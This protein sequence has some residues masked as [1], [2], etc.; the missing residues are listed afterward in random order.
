M[1]KKF[2]EFIYYFW[3]RFSI[4]NF[5][6]IMRNMYMCV[7]WDDLQSKKPILSS[8]WILWGFEAKRILYHGAHQNFI[9][10]TYCLTNFKYISRLITAKLPWLL[11]WC[12]NDCMWI[13]W[14]QIQ[15]L[16]QQRKKNR[17]LLLSLTVKTRDI[18]NWEKQ[19]IYQILC[20]VSLYTVADI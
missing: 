2:T 5:Y 4:P 13:F 17:H 11:C 7:L 3:Q 14:S 8:I 12:H 18:Q 9:I 15:K 16:Q 1:S 6:N 19:G 20:M 10:V